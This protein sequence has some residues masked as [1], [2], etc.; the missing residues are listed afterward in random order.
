MFCY[1]LMDY[2]GDKLDWAQYGGLR[3]NSIS[4]YLIEFTNFILYNQDL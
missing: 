3:G 2:V 4:H 1:W